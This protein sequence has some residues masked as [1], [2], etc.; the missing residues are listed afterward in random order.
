[1][2]K[3]G[4]M[5]YV[6]MGSGFIPLIYLYRWDRK[7]NTREDSFEDQLIKADKKKKLITVQE[8]RLMGERIKAKEVPISDEEGGYM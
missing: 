2:A 4:L 6:V 8:Q 3:R 1:M 5:Y 7:N